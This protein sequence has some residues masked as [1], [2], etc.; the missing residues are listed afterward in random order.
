[1]NIQYPLTIYYDAAC[2][3]CKSEMETLKQTDYDNKLILID[4]SNIDLE[5]PA[6]CPVTRE[7]MMERIHAI[8]ANGK[9]IKSVDVF[10]A[11]YAAS[12]FNRLA[13]IWGSQTLRPI[14]S[15][16]YPWVADNRHWLSRSPL[17]YLLNKALRMCANKTSY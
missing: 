16:A 8:D 10:E 6:S 5:T 1:M 4:C 12:G 3:M 13:K 17:P 2:P 9:W 15:R 14:L 11:A 7:A